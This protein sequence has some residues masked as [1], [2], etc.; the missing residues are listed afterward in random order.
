MINT[1]AVLLPSFCSAI[2]CPASA[3]AEI[4]YC[5]LV[6]NNNGIVGPVNVSPGA[7][8]GTLMFGIAGV[9]PVCV[10]CN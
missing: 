10:T 7:N 2:I 3:T 6:A 5:P 1:V 9:P 4:E 8:A